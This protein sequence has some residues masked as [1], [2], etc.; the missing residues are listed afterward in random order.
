ML[1]LFVF[2]MKTFLFNFDID[3][4]ELPAAVNSYQKLRRENTFSLEHN[5]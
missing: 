3:D 2:L 1:S 4:L 5:S